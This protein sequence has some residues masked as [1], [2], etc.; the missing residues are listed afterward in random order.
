MKRARTIAGEWK[1]ARESEF[2][3]LDSGA[4]VGAVDGHV[5]FNSAA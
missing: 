2:F 3:K 1:R 5:D 4:S